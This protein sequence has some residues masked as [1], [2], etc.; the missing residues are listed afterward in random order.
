M[1]RRVPCPAPGP[2]EGPVHAEPY[3]PARHFA[4]GKNDPAF[5]TKLKIGADLAVRVTNPFR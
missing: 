2:L 3:T 5:R 4:R 1:T